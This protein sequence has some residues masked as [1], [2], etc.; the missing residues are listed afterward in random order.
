MLLQGR[1]QGKF[2]GRGSD[3]PSFLGPPTSLTNMFFSVVGYRALILEL[4]S[5][6]DLHVYLDT[7]ATSY[8]ESR[9]H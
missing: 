2:G 5:Q 1:S 6:L 3:E 4:H 7:I 9:A 8:A